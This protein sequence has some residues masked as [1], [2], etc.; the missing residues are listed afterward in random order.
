MN[1]LSG[2]PFFAVFL[3]GNIPVGVID[4]LGDKVLHLLPKRLVVVRLNLFFPHGVQS[5][6]SLV[7]EE[8]SNFSFS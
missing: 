4:V 1:Y 6:G 5:D 7:V 3:D 8:S 2:L